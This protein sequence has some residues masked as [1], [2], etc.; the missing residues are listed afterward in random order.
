[1]EVKRKEVTRVPVSLVMV[2]CDRQF[3]WIKKCITD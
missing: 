3:G 2:N 1:M